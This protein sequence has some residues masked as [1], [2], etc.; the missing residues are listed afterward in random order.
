MEKLNLELFENIQTKARYSPLIWSVA[1]IVLP[2]GLWDFTER[3]WQ[4]AIME[5]PH[6]RIVS[7]KPSQVGETTIFI[8]KAL[9]FMHYR[10]TRVIWTF[11]RQEDVSEFVTTR[12]R[13]ILHNSP[14]IA[15]HVGQSRDDPQS[16]R[17]TKYKNSYTTADLLANDEVDRS[18]PD[19]L[20]AFLGRLENSKYK[21]HYRFSTPTIPNFG[22]DRIFNEESDQRYWMVRCPHCGHRQSLKWDVNLMFDKNDHPYYGCEKCRRDLTPEAIINGEYVAMYPSRLVHGYQVSGMML[23]LSKPPVYMY[24]RFKT[25]KRKNFYNL[26]LGETYEASGL[27]FD[28]EVILS[29][30]FVPTEEPYQHMY[31][32]KGDTYMGVDQKG[33]LH[34]Q[35]TWTRLVG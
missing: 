22:I 26:L 20:E 11:P 17:I 12:F 10:R 33:D 1:N 23:P 5:D 28:P 25:M 19:N 14:N 4:I 7:K 16:Q 3:K 13:P 18:D 15:R 35:A 32:A 34:V 31:S 9:W 29:N 8:C 24:Q 2:D 21:I 27:K 30:V 6:P